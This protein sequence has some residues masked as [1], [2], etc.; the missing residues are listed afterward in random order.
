M[1]GAQKF[2]MGN[3]TLNTPVSGMVFVIRRLGLVRSTYP[4]YQFD[5]SILTHYEDMEGDAK[6]RN[7]GSLRLLGVI[8]ANKRVH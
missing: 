3:G 5:V 7:L 6:C 1:I 8:L 2:T 4:T